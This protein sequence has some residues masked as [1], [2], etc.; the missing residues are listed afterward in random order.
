MLEEIY[1]LIS[2]HYN[3]GVSESTTTCITSSIEDDIVYQR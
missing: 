3:I 1:F 2:N